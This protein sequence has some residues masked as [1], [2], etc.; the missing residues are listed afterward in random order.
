M[1]LGGANLIVSI[2]GACILIFIGRLFT[3]SE[4]KDVF[5][6]GQKALLASLLPIFPFFYQGKCYICVLSKYPFFENV[7]EMAYSNN[8]MII[9]HELLSKL[10]GLWDK[11]KPSL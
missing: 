4:L 10:V 8:V 1:A 7:I 5:L 6:L 3:R 2:I 11:K 9:R